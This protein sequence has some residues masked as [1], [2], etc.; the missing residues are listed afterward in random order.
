MTMLSL[1][2]ACLPEP[3][4]V[5]TD[6]QAGSTRILLDPR[7]AH[8][9]IA[10][11]MPGGTAAAG[12]HLQQLRALPL[13]VITLSSQFCDYPVIRGLQSDGRGGG[14]DSRH[15]GLPRFQGS[16]Q[17]LQLPQ[18]SRLLLPAVP[19][20]PPHAASATFVPA[21]HVR[22]QPSTAHA[23][24]SSSGFVTLHRGELASSSSSSS[25]L[26]S[27]CSQKQLRVRESG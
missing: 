1:H 24:D 13:Q 26:P 21:Q 2:L 4:Q 8:Q 16:V 27:G 15:L 14:L 25:M 17:I 9:L 23:A 5:Q 18:C 19:S 7:H 20:A 10:T 22:C 11:G 3:R 12:P 6:C